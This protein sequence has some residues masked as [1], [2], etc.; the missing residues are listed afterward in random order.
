MGKWHN[1]LKEVDGN[2]Q[3]SQDVDFVASKWMGELIVLRTIREHAEERVWHYPWYMTDAWNLRTDAWNREREGQAPWVRVH[4]YL[5][6]LKRFW[7]KKLDGQERGRK[8]EHRI[9]VLAEEL[10]GEEEGCTCLAYEEAEMERRKVQPPWNNHHEVA[11]YDRDTLLWRDHGSWDCGPSGVT[12][13]RS[14]REHSPSTWDQLELTNA[15][16]VDIE[17]LENSLKEYQR[18]LSPSELSSRT[19]VF[20]GNDDPYFYEVIE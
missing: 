18:S 4:H 10:N 16:S 20:S 12:W 7:W 9:E 3:F 15:A 19:F 11:N 2:D 17:W 8:L 5:F 1:I 6:E 14:G 13:H